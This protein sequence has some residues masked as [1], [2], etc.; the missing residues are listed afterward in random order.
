M[1]L[2]ATCQHCG[3]DGAIGR[4]IVHRAGCPMY[5]HPHQIREAS[6]AWPPEVV[7]SCPDV[8]AF[9]LT[10][11]TGT[12]QGIAELWA[13]GRI[14]TPQDCVFFERRAQLHYETTG[15]AVPASAAELLEQLRERAAIGR[16][17]AP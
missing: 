2:R 7:P 11:A 17:E 8:C 10:C 6:D 15:R 13:E 14:R 1:T 12:Q 4:S 3:A 9:R 5:L 16:E